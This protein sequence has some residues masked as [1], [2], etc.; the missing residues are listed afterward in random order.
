MPLPPD[1]E[2]GPRN[3]GLESSLKDTLERLKAVVESA[4]IANNVPTFSGSESRLFSDWVK[5]IE[6][7]GLLSRVEPI[8]YKLIAY[9]SARGPVSSFIKRRLSNEHTKGESWESFK[10]QLASRF[11]YIT[12]ESIAFL[13]LRRAKQ[14]KEE[15]VVLFSERLINLADGCFLGQNVDSGYV[16][17]EVLNIFINGLRS[18]TLMYRLMKANPKSLNDAISLALN[19]ETLRKR[20]DLR[21]RRNDDLPRSQVQREPRTDARPTEEMMEVDHLRPSRARQ[22]RGEYCRRCQNH[23][24]RN[25]PCR[26][27]RGFVN[28]INHS[29]KTVRAWPDSKCNKCQGA[30]PTWKCPTN[31]IN[32]PIHRRAGAIPS[33]NSKSLCYRCHQPGHFARS[34][35]NKENSEN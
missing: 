17:K 25:A 3:P 5:S 4:N 1:N 30:H 9:H 23:H 33:G 12:D 6:K 35:P 16:E 10:A 20:F 2:F 28:A 22:S 21:L 24:H 8:D 18:E 19:E 26:P 13:M 27:R 7:I 29:T 15:S 14:E 32:Q 34:C 31:Q 11:A